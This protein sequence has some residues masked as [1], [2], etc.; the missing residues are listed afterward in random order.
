MFFFLFGLSLCFLNVILLFFLFV[1][2][3]ILGVDCFLNLVF[4]LLVF[5]VEIFLVLILFDGVVFILIRE[6]R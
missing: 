1:W 2:K 3:V 5:D 4:V 6:E